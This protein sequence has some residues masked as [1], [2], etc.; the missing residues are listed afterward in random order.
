MIMRSVAAIVA[1]ATVTGVAVPVLGGPVD[2]PSGPVTSTMK[3]LDLVEA[4]TAV[5]A[6]TCPGDADSVCRITQPGSYYLVGNVDGVAGKHGIEI[7]ASG[8]SLDLNGFTLA[9]VAGSLCGVYT[10]STSED[11][12]V[13]NGRVT[14]WGEDGVSVVVVVGQRCGTIENVV[15]SHNGERGIHAGTGAVV[16][17][18][19]AHDNGSVGISVYTSAV[20]ESCSAFANGNNGISGSE[21]A[22]ITGCSAGGNAGL[23]IYVGTGGTITGCM[24]RWNIGSG[25]W[26]SHGGTIRGCTAYQN[27][28]DGINVYRGTHVLENSCYNNNG[29]TSA[30]IRVRAEGNRIENNNVA[31][32]IYGIDVDAAGNIVICNSARGNTTSAFSIPSGNTYGPIVSGG[33]GQIST[34]NPWAN[35]S[36]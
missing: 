5:T 32:N 25:I 17:G 10:S 34:T 30:G 11:V 7:E 2:P 6:E 4:R 33:N 24:A 13:R 14:G 9:G 35:F 27:Q 8:V 22:T 12:G 1:L 26:I 19:T 18:C 31:G 3:P 21:G 29:A 20:V 28:G 23:G 36:F 15:S 16:R